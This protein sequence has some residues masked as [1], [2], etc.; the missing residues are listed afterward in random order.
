MPCDES[1]DK[2]ARCGD[3]QSNDNH[4]DTAS[5]CPAAGENASRRADHEVSE[6]A[7]RQEGFNG[8]GEGRTKG[9]PVGSHFYV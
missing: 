3:S 1:A 7:D 4:V 6:H 5:Q 9:G 8:V 2:I